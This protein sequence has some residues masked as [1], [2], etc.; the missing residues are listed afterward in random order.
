MESVD[1]ISYQEYNIFDCWFWVS[2]REQGE[3]LG[4]SEKRLRGFETKEASVPDGHLSNKSTNTQ[5]INAVLLIRILCFEVL[6]S[7]LENGRVGPTELD[8]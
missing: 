7:A 8:F 4:P 1:T 3:L 2:V 5:S 6:L